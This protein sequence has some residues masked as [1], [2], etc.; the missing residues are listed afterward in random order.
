VVGDPVS[1]DNVKK[2]FIDLFFYGFYVYFL[3]RF[4]KKIA[5]IPDALR[6]LNQLTA[7]LS[8]VN[9]QLSTVNC[10]LSII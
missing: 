8:T 3:V 5:K 7:E 9:C 4:A 6:K 1:G 2:S 10:Q